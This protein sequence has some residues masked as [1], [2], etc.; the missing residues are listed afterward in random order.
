MTAP[1]PG[2]AQRSAELLLHLYETRRETTL[3]EAREWWVTKFHPK[4]AKDVLA[5]WVAPDSGPYRMVTTYWEMACSF[6]THGAIDP[7][8]FHASNTEYLAVY[9]KME[10][11][12]A[13][14][15][16]LT[17]YPGYLRE[18][19]AVVLALPDREARL[20]PIRRF[21]KRRA[22]EAGAA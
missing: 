19:E 16:E 22:V 1:D 14:L 15:R 11:H 10:P 17:A 3:R 20:A 6:V 18:L 7:G 9:A 5:T 8:M 21:L 13:E 2:F 12:L 4:S